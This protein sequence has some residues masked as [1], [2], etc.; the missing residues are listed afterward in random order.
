[1]N[2]KLIL[3]N[4]GHAFAFPFVLTV[5]WFNIKSANKK[6]KD[7]EINPEFYPIEERYQRVYKMVKKAFFFLNVR[8]IFSGLENVPKKPVLFVPNHKS[9][10]DPLI[11]IKILQENPGAPYFNFVS[12]KEIAENPFAKG[13]S[14]LIDSLVLDRGNPREI[15]KVLTKEEEL[16]K[17]HSIVSFLEGTRIESDTI[18]E[19]KGAGLAPAINTLTTIVPVAIYGT[20][21]VLKPKEDKRFKYKEF[22]VRFLKPIKNSEYIGKDRDLL[23]KNIQNIIEKEYNLIKELVEKNANKNNK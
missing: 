15:I 10:I 6:A 11:F 12:K 1:M 7:Y 13:G 22:H 18:G 14:V 17:K 4:I 20:I 23:A 5:L 16:I 8:V 2:L 19:F 3:R 21:G 9:N